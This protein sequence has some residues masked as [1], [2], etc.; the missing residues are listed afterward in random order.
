MLTHIN[1]IIKSGDN[2]GTLTATVTGTISG[3]IDLNDDIS[4]IAD[5]L[6]YVV[7]DEE[8]PTP[9]ELN[10]LINENEFNTITATIEMR[11]TDAESLSTRS[12]DS[13][14]IIANADD[15]NGSP[16]VFEGTLALNF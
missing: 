3:L 5:V 11:S 2:E 4:E 1:N 14:T 8:N 6:N 7:N 15:E 9:S 16:T 12:T 13:I 10:Q